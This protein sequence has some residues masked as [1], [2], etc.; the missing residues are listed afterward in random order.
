MKLSTWLQ[1]TT[2]HTGFAENSLY[3]FL[4]AFYRFPMLFYLI[5]SE[6]A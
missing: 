2:P 1:L 3:F 4:N 6:G 5:D